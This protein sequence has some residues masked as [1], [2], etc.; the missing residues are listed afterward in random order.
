MSDCRENGDH[1]IQQIPEDTKPLENQVAGHRF[2]HCLNKLG[3]LRHQS[4]QDILKPIC[5][6]RSE[7]EFQ[8][9]SLIWKSDNDSDNDSDQVVVQLRQFVPKHNGIFID[10][11]S[12]NK[13]LRLKDVT[14]GLE[15]PSVLD[16]KIGPRTYDLEAN[17]DKIKSEMNKYLFAQQ[18]GFR[19]LGMR[20]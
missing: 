10:K 19:I 15:K 13:Y 2:G 18:I 3:L 5:D 17:Q 1:P 14:I 6:P 11:N 9:Y 7:R 16:V 4:S 8:L 20:V 12:D